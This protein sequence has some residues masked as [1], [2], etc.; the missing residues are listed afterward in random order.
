MRT[1]RYLG[2]LPWRSRPALAAFGIATAG[3]ALGH[4]QVAQ[5]QIWK[6]V[7]ERAADRFHTHAAQMDSVVEA[8]TGRLI[9]S[10]LLKASRG[11]EQAVDAGARVVD[12]TLS[13]SE[14]TFAR[15][16]GEGDSGGLAPAL[17]SGHLVLRTVEFGRNSEILSPKAD[18][19]LKELAQALQVTKGTY[20]IEGHTDLSSDPATSQVLSERRAAA[21]KGRL[22]AEG[23]PADR[24]FTVGYGG[25]RP[26]TAN[27]AINA[28]E[29]G[30]ARIEIR[31]MH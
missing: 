31:R 10:T 28:R 9:D 22:V 12:T 3:I 25:S 14:R 23:V 29:Q 27:G 2:A 11:A 19:V 6:R 1:V 18:A 7:A 24:L 8:R 30:E 17:E 21:V 15:V 13:R 5:G 4:P 26:D 16:L 20:L